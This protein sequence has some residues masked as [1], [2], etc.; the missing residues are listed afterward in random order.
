VDE[1]HMSFGH[2]WIGWQDET[3]LLI[4]KPVSLLL[5]L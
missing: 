3:K 5:C 2:W 1:L 4:R